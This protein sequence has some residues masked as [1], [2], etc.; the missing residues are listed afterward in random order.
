MDARLLVDTVEC[1]DECNVADG[2]AIKVKKVSQVTLQSST[3]GVT[4]KVTMRDVI[5]QSISRTTFYRTA[6]FKKKEYH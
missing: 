6:N 1:F 5:V 3:D 4:H 2:Q